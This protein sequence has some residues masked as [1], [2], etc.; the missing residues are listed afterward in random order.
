MP[1]AVQDLLDAGADPNAQDKDGATP[2]HWAVADRNPAE[3]L[4]IARVGDTQP[5]PALRCRSLK[6]VK[7]LLDSRANLKVRDKKGLTPLHWAAALSKTPEVVKALVDAGADSNAREDQ[8][9]HTPLHEAAR[10]RKTPEVVKVLLDAGADPN[11]QDKYGVTPL[12]VATQ[13]NM[14]A[15]GVAQAIRDA[16]G[17]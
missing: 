8:L 7:A 5:S 14:G 11:A 2:L 12:S 3:P 4:P 6:V 9:G 13:E 10:R 15:P 16:G 1:A 17:R